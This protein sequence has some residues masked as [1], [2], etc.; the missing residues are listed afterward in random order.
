[1]KPTSKP[2]SFTSPFI[3]LYFSE[4]EAIK[5]QKIILAKEIVKSESN[6]AATIENCIKREQQLNDRIEQLQMEF[7]IKYDEFVSSA[8]NGIVYSSN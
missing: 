3:L 6:L 4:L 8:I 7:D 5:N 1:M 2:L